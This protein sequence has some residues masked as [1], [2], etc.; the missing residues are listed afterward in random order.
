MNVSGHF[1]NVDGMDCKIVTFLI[2]SNHFFKN[3]NPVKSLKK[4][5][6]CFLSHRHSKF[7]IKNIISKIFNAKSIG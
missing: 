4:K 2:M 5:K 1:T 7:S 3:L 6:S